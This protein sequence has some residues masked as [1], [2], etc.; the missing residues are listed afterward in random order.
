MPLNTPIP[1]KDFTCIM[2]DEAT[3]F[4]IHF[5]IFIDISSHSII[6]HNSYSCHVFN[7]E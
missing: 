5:S 4:I 6:P 2:G 7:T 3:L 1:L